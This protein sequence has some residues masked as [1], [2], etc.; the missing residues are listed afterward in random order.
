M[1]ICIKKLD[2]GLLRNF[3]SQIA[4]ISLKITLENQAHQVKIKGKKG[5]EKYEK[6]NYTVQFYTDKIFVLQYSIKVL[7]ISK[8]QYL[9]YL[10]S[11]KM[12]IFGDQNLPNLVLDEV[13]KVISFN[14]V[15]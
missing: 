7:G 6:K 4:R 13:R 8:A 11:I 1:K 14:E 2:L 5:S 9:N 15:N 3:V 10:C 12:D